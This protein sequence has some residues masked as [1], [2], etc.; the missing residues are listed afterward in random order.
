[1]VQNKVKFKRKILIKIIQA[2]AVFGLG[3]Y[4]SFFFSQKI[5]KISED[6]VDK[7]QT[8]ED[9][10]ARN[11]GK[12]QLYNEYETAKPYLEQVNKFLYSETEIAKLLSSLEKIT[13][14]TNNQ[15]QIQIKGAKPYSSE[16]K[17]IEIEEVE[18]T[19]TLSGNYDSFL[20]YCKKIEDFSYPIKIKNINL[21]IS[22][23]I[24]ESGVMIFD[25]SF[26]LK[27]ENIE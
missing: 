11:E 16:Q 23:G 24:G 8:I 5:D 10:Q 1:M 22:S 20:N 26:L 2:I 13:E 14:E 7:K 25:S 17:E 12:T 4:F 27:K 6:L 19:I 18:Y 21:S 3:V 15:Q 9:I